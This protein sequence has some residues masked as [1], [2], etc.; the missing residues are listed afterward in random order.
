MRLETGRRVGYEGTETEA[1][2]FLS[3]GIARKKDKGGNGNWGCTLMISDVLQPSS[4]LMGRKRWVRWD[5]RNSKGERF[6]SHFLG[7]GRL[8]LIKFES[9]MV[10]RVE[11]HSQTKRSH[12][13]IGGYFSIRVARVVNWEPGRGWETYMLA[14]WKAQQGFQKFGVPLRDDLRASQ[15]EGRPL[16]TWWPMETENQPRRP[17]LWQKSTGSWTFL[18]YKFWKWK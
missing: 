9:R 7:Q 16:N 17:E 10:K 8:V 4:G 3:Q 11:N 1:P 2:K 18:N 14:G 13:H 12:S 6:S 15:Q 5:L